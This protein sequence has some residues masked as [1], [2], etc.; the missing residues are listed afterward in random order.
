M[1]VIAGTAKGVRLGVVPPGARP[2]ADR[3]REGLFSSLGGRVT[4]HSDP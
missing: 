1:R 3:A 2:V 4:S